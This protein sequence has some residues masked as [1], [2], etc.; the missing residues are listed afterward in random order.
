MQLL[1]FA[2]LL[3]LAAATASAKAVRNIKPQ[4]LAEAF[5]DAFP[6]Q[7]ARV[8]EAANGCTAN[9]TPMQVR[10][11]YGGPDGMTVSWNTNQRLA[12]PVRRQLPC[13]GSISQF[14][15]EISCHLLN[16]PFQNQDIECSIK[17][18]ISSPLTFSRGTR[19]NY[20]ILGISK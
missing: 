14:R 16:I 18:L 12:N 9:T 19:S 17:R 7:A 10:L 8:D 2:A 11:A 3:S 5:P 15:L 13:R 20:C 1:H 4:S 6:G